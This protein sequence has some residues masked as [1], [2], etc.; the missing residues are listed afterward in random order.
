MFFFFSQH[1]GPEKPAGYH[2]NIDADIDSLTSMLADLDSHTQDSSTQVGLF[3]S[4]SGVVTCSFPSSLFVSTQLYDNVPYNK[5]LS[6]DQYKSA[7]QNSASPQSRPSLGYPGHPQSQYHPVPP[8]SSESTQ[9]SSSHQQDYYSSSSSAPKPYPQP[10]PAS[11][12]TASTPTGPRFSV[13]VKTAQPV[14]YSQSGRQAEQAYTPPPPRQHVPR[15]PPQSQANL[16]GW[17]PPH[18]AQEMHV[19]AGYKGASG[20]AGRVNPVPQSKRAVENNQSGSGD[21]Q[22]L[23]YQSNKV[24]TVFTTI[25]RSF[26][27][28][29]ILKMST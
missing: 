17:Y 9:Y 19:E 7:H 11:Y 24:G 10:I 8:Y 3:S 18:Q 22:T 5:Y 14:T 27:S 12:T 26:L 28:L 21:L 13:Q 4:P 2:S 20:S 25:F 23:P 15:P 29:N 6:G 1:R 16:Q